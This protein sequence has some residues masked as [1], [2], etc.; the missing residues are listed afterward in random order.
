[1]K[2]HGAER[3]TMTQGSTGGRGEMEG[4]KREG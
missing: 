4:W 3:E 2:A 1:M